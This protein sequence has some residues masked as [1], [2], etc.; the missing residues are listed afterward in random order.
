MNLSEPE[1]SRVTTAN[2]FE[3]FTLDLGN[4]IQNGPDGIALVN[5]TTHEVIHFLSYEGVFAGTEGIALGVTSTNIAVTFL[6]GGDTDGDGQSDAMESIFGTNPA[7]ASSRFVVALAYQTPSPGMLRLSF[8][9]VAGRS[10][11]VESCTDFTDWAEE[12]TYPGTGGPRLADFPIVSQD[13]RRFYRVR[14]ALQ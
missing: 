8:P 5:R 13:P 6:T 2:S 12:E 7:D 3:L 1:F 9:T 11:M 10:Y 14:V 4:A